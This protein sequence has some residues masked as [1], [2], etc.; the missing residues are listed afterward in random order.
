MVKKLK[1]LPIT[2]LIWCS[3]SLV[4]WQGFDDAL[5]GSKAGA[6]KTFEIQYPADHNP[7][8]L[9]GKTV[10]YEVTFNS[11]AQPVLP[12]VDAEFA[13]SLGVEDGNV[14]TMAAIKASLEQ[15]NRKNVSRHV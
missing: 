10:S 2:V 1:E 9:A 6:T 3:V 15:E 4:V 5:V 11:G 7:A 8:Q 14:D 12:A 13:K